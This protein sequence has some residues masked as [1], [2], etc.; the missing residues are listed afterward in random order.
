MRDRQS[1]HGWLEL[2]MVPYVCVPLAGLLVVAF[3]PW[4]TLAVPG[5]L[6]FAP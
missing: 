5:A 3:V 4:F 6:D 1:A 2:A